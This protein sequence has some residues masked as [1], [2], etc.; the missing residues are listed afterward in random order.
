MKRILKIF[1]LAVFIASVSASCTGRGGKG[2]ESAEVKHFRQVAVPAVYTSQREIITYAAAHFWDDFAGVPDIELEAAMS[3]FLN[4]LC[5]LP[6]DE[7]QNAMV[8]LFDNIVRTHNADTSAH[9]Y[10][11]MT[12]LVSK[13][14]YDPNSPARNEDLYLPFVQKLASC[15]LTSEEMRP[16][17]EYEAQSCSKCRFGTLAPDFRIRTVKG[18]T[19]H[20]HSVEGEFTMLLFSNPGCTACK[21]IIDNVLASPRVAGMIESGYLAVINVYIDQD[22]KAWRE[23]EHN[24]PSNWH[25]GYD[26]DYVVR[27]ENLYPVRAIPSLYLLDRQKHIIMKDAPTERVTGYLETLKIK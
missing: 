2:A 9:T 7:A 16:A 10:I 18:N 20:M 11:R 26:P 25:T 4:L 15:P 6:L 1:F 14:L 22:L 8:S 21:E 3:D 27:G 17:Y 23:Y 24:Y 19:F 13:Y 12:Q 5:G